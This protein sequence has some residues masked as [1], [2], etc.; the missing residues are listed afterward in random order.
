MGCSPKQI[1]RIA[2]PVIVGLIPSAQ[3]LAVAIA[4]ASAT[5][6]TGGSF[7]ET[8]IAGGTSFIGAHIGAG[9][10]EAI[11]GAGAIPVSEGVGGAFGGELLLQNAAQQSAFNAAGAGASA[12][13]GG[14]TGFVSE[15]L[16][17]HAPTAVQYLNTTFPFADT[18]AGLAG[19]ELFNGATAQ[20]VLSQVGGMTAGTLGAKTFGAALGMTLESTINQML[21]AQDFE[22]LRSAGFK[23]E[24]IQILSAERKRQLIE[25]VYDKLVKAGASPEQ[26]ITAAEQ[27]LPPA[28]G[29]IPLT[30]TIPSLP[31][32][33]TSNNSPLDPNDEF[34]NPFK[35]EAE[36]KSV[37][38][39]GL[40]EIN[41]GIGGI[42]KAQFDQLFSDIPSVGNKILSTEERA[43]RNAFTKKLQTGI[44]PSKAFQPTV[45]DDIITK[46]LDEEQAPAFQQVANIEARGA[47]NLLGGQTAKQSIT[48][49]R[50]RGQER[51]DQI[52]SSVRE[53][54]IGD[55]GAIRDQ[56]LTEAENYKLGDELFNP[57]KYTSQ[58]SDLEKQRS[59]GLESDIRSQL[60]DEELFDVGS[61]SK[62]AGRA[63]GVVSGRPSSNALLDAIAQRGLTEEARKRRG[64]GTRGS[65]A[66]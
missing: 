15:L 13:A 17:E 22:G 65:G 46:I 44:D 16:A 53:R 59:S 55:I 1:F 43:R 23:D 26:A 30:G 40:N 52:G 3:P 19:K 45:D 12:G 34:K 32:T 63:Q 56:G 5:A 11:S 18:A 33:Q 24:A 2:I 6:V 41:K 48:K 47:F 54:N 39:S 35:D 38:A 37:M 36:F 49:Q 64:L 51:L 9:I 42:T 27:T 61:A 14:A 28:L 62:E 66:F 25:E 31:Q 29:A 57:E 21:D 20:Q 8:L 10:G 60:G 7:K 4:A 50:T 58:A